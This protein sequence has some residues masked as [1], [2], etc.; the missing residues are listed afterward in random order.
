MRAVVGLAA[1]A[2]LLCICGE[3]YAAPRLVFCHYMLWV[4]GVSDTVDG[5]AS[6]MRLAKSYGIDAFAVN[7]AQWYSDSWP[8]QRMQRFKQAAE[9]VG[10]KFFMSA[11]VTVEFINNPGAIVDMI[12]ALAPS[13]AYLRVNNQPFLSTFVG[14]SV[15]WNWQTSVLNPL[16]GKGLTPYFVPFFDGNP[17]DVANRFPYASGF[18]HWTAW[19]YQ[20][21]DLQTV[22]PSF[23]NTW[24][25]VAQSKGKTFMAPISPYFVK[26][27]CG[28]PADAKPNWV[29]GNYKGPGLW[30]DHW[31]QL[32]NIAPDFIEIVTWNDY[33]EGSYIGPITAQWGLSDKC[34]G[35]P[36]MY[37]RVGYPHDAYAD[38]GAFFINAY[39]QYGNYSFSFKDTVYA[40]YR[41]FSKNIQ[42]PD[43]TGLGPIQ[44]GNSM[45]DVIYIITLLNQPAT[46]QLTSGSVTKT[47]SVGTGLATSAMPFNTGSQ[48]VKVLRNNAQVA[49]KTFAKQITTSCTD[50]NLYDVNTYSE[51]FKF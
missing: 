34:N 39:K 46:L 29:F 17:S 38:L 9:Q 10:F 6:E 36:T 27:F 37:D 42:C 7:T 47:F 12:A 22:N 30:I 11:D 23:D 50:G 8:P 20:N 40:F 14:Q 1:L 13:G 25:S 16:A 28:L 2:V 5:F 44:N 31:Q 3:V 41:P 49:A 45:D 15:S 33:P 4:P 21:G 24:K 32:I 43:P 26:H 19:P 51:F 35:G 48:S 18:F